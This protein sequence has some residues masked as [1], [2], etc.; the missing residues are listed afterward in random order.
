MLAGGTD[1]MVKVGDFWIDKY[2][3][4]AWQNADCTGTQYGASADNWSTGVVPGGAGG[5]DV[6]IEDSVVDI[7]YG[8][9]QSGIGNTLA[10]AVA[11]PETLDMLRQETDEIICLSAPA[12]FGAISVFYSDFQQVGDEEV[13]DLLSRAAKFAGRKISSSIP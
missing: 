10:V 11:P 7:L 3:M 12:Y 6:F 4:S 1:R 2:E 9:D 13:A 8:L 5:Q